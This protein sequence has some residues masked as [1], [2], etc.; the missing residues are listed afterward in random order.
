[1]FDLAVQWYELRGWGA[2]PVIFNLPAQQSHLSGV[3]LTS[4]ARLVLKLRAQG[5]GVSLCALVMA[6]C[7]YPQA[8][9]LC[10]CVLTVCSPQGVERLA[11]L[12]N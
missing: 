4:T 3:A 5:S 12:S 6:T 11:N 8:R 9:C 2:A 10:M 7:G 1:M